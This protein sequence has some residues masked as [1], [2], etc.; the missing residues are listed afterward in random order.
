MP[1]AAND[2]DSPSNMQSADLFDFPNPPSQ[3]P[4]PPLP[5]LEA[6]PTDTGVHNDFEHASQVEE[7]DQRDVTGSADQSPLDLRHSGLDASRFSRISRSTASLPAFSKRDPYGSTAAEDAPEDGLKPSRMY[8]QARAAKSHHNLSC[9]EDNGPLSQS[10]LSLMSKSEQM[11]EV[12][13]LLSPIENCSYE[14]DMGKSS[15]AATLV[16]HAPERALPPP[17]PAL[18]Q[19]SP[20]ISSIENGDADRPVVQLRK[21]MSMAQIETRL[22]NR[23]SMIVSDMLFPGGDGFCSNTLP[24]RQQSQERTKRRQSRFQLD[25]DFQ[26]DKNSRRVSRYLY[27]VPSSSASNG[28]QSTISRAL[29]WSQRIS[30]SSHR[31]LHRTSSSII[32][33]HKIYDIYEES[34]WHTAQTP[35]DT[36]ASGTA[37]KAGPGFPFGLSTSAAASNQRSVSA[38]KPP[39]KADALNG[40]RKHILRTVKSAGVPWNMIRSWK[41]R[42]A[43]ASKET[44]WDLS[45]VSSASVYSDSSSDYCGT[46]SSPA[47]IS[48]KQ[49]TRKQS[50]IQL[51]V[52]RAGRDLLRRSTSFYK[53]I[54]GATLATTNSHS[55]AGVMQSSFSGISSASSG[56]SAPVD[57]PKFGN[58]FT[59]VMRQAGSKLRGTLR[60]H[61][62]SRAVPK[63]DEVVSAYPT[64]SLTGKELDT[65]LSMSALHSPVLPAPANSRASS[66]SDDANNRGNLAAY[67]PPKQPPYLGLHRND[68]VF[69]ARCDDD[70]GAEADSASA[71]PQAVGHSASGVRLRPTQFNSPF[72]TLPYGAYVQPHHQTRGQFHHM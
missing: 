15:T 58:R 24:T 6:T 25:L 38:S 27:D 52:K 17:M 14:S 16:S 45:S 69:S 35:V 72:T 54:S 32:D 33:Q 68:R 18:R 23:N 8:L 1:S 9:P 36:A 48:N 42:H 71:L 4:E 62:K 49:P 67:A 47:P 10:L 50:T 2:N 11:P 60:M 70:A 53:S 43:Q 21:Q 28:M 26:L 40:A 55:T 46:F 44:E 20:D 51:F 5:A 22:S 64:D 65:Y 39:A 3:N 56:A 30:Q 12:A 57:K 13:D 59:T 66:G 63:D 37:A 41:N 31:Q 29:Q 34:I 61:D 7:I 19:R